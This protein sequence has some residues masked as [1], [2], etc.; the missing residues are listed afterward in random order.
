MGGEG[1][2]N[3]QRVISTFFIH[4]TALHKKESTYLDGAQDIL[5]PIVLTE[6]GG[7]FLLFKRKEAYQ[8]LISHFHIVGAYWS[9]ALWGSCYHLCDWLGM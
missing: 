9:L 1:G 3:M 6:K 4:F 7:W 8:M 5:W 2:L